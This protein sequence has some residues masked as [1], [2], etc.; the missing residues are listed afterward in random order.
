MSDS[1]GEVE[2]PPERRAPSARGSKG[3]RMA[4]LLRD[5]AD[6][7]ADDA[8]KDFYTQQF[9]AEDEEDAD[10]ADADDEAARDSF[11]SD[12]GDSSESDDD[13]D[14]EEK[15]AKAAKKEQA[16]RKK[17]VYK[18][19]KAAKKEGGEA[20]A[21]SASAPPKPKA[22]GKRKARGEAEA[23]LAEAGGGVGRESMRASTKNATELAVEKRKVAEEMQKQRAEHASKVGKAKGGVELRRLTQEELL[24]EA[25]QTE[26][27]NKASLQKMLQQ[28]E[29]K[30][31]VVVRSTNHSGPRVKY[32]SKR[33]GDSVINTQ[34]FIDCPIPECIDAVAPPYALP[35]KCPV[36]GLPAK[37]F[38]P[39]SNQP[40]ANLDAFKALRGRP[41]RRQQ[42]FALPAA[43]AENDGFAN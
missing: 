6:D 26:I 15:A 33:I 35:L 10:F 25:R 32:S 27:I 42:S 5:E 34:T 37:Y 19:P 2:K 3:S 30:R 13:E 20:A 14:E 9:W 36:T 17:S 21:S 41:G 39:V 22:G 4:A 29:E 1:D 40:Y 31:K 28:Q 12:F 43:C 18:D 24:A 8:D 7:E 38:D 11:D 23:L 16:A